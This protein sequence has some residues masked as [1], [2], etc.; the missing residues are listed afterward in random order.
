MSTYLVSNAK[1]FLF[2]RELL[3]IGVVN[4]KETLQF[5]MGLPKTTFDKATIIC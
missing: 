5:V 1:F 3:H 2:V 4:I